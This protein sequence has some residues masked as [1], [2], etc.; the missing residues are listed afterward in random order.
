MLKN[1]LLILSHQKS[2]YREDQK[3]YLLENNNDKFIFYY[4]IGD[5]KLKNNYKVDEKNKIVYLK[6]ADNYESLSLKTYYAIK[7]ISEKYLTKI[8]GIFKTDDDIRLDLD[9]LSDCIDINQDSKY[10]GLVADS[11]AY[12]STYHFGKCESDL[13]NK[14]SI[15]IPA[16]RYC[17][18]GGYYIS[19][20]LVANVLNSRAIYENII[21]EDVCMGLSMNRYGVFPKD[22]NMKENGCDWEN[23]TSKSGEIIQSEDNRASMFESAKKPEPFLFPMPV[24]LNSNKCPCG[25]PINKRASNFCQK[26][27]RLY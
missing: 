12:K 4:F 22:I 24:I 9:K 17:A 8:S 6:V 27:N 3:K 2:T 16:C 18:G 7:F 5:Q 11:P 21:F 19:K 14:R 25:E 23:P 20:S 10:F 1:F 13:L 26:C 15:L